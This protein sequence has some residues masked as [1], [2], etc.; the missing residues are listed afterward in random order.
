M[1][2]ELL[3]DGVS[4]HDIVQGVL[5]DC[6]FLS[7]CSA[8][9]QRP[10][11]MEKPNT[12]DFFLSLDMSPIEHVWDLVGRRLAR[13]PS[14]YRFKRR[15]WVRIQAIWNCLPLADIPRRIETLIAASGGY[16]KY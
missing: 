12:C 1:R 3:V 8:V 6:W 11:L 4:R 10:D 2:P 16:T 13:D 14:Y 15:I 7:S 9:A 5:A